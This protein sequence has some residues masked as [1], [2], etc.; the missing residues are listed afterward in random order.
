MH[1]VTALPFPL[2]IALVAGPAPDALDAPDAAATEGEPAS[3][4]PEPT[5]TTPEP[6]SAEPEPAS[7]TSEPASA[8]SDAAAPAPRPPR[9]DGPYLG[10][11]MFGGLGLLRVND[12]DTPGPFS[13]AGATASVGQMV[14]PW[15][16][17]G[18]HGGGSG[19]VRSADGARQ[20]LGQ[21][22][23]GVEFKFVP[24]PKRLP[25]LSLRTS[26]GFGGGAVRQEGIA[27]RSGFGGAQFSGAV[28]YELFPWAARRRPY[29]GGGFGLGPELGWVG[30]TPAAA[31]RPMSNVV[32]LALT[33]TFYFGS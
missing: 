17:L 24:L 29:R 16:G 11:T 9:I 12:F 31:G 14:F 23:L 18:L 20:R 32:Y 33:T 10:A 8:T 2:V 27:Q 22:H 19:G 5:S 26:F 3:A 21:G 30:F 4:E 6:A 7:A 25:L 15:L 13:V 28:R 1:A